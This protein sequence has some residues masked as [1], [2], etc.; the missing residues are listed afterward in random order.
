VGVL[1][2][3]GTDYVLDDRSARALPIDGHR[4]RLVRGL[5]P[6]AG[7]RLVRLRPAPGPAPMVWPAL[8]EAVAA[9]LREHLEAPLGNRG[10]AGIALLAGRMRDPSHD[11]GWRRRFGRGAAMFQA[12]C[13]LFRFIEHGAG[14]GLGRP[15]FANALR[16]LAREGGFAALAEHAERWRAIGSMWSAVADGALPFSVPDLGRARQLL[17]ARHENFLADG[18]DGPGTA[19]AE[20]LAPLAR[21]MDQAFPL[22]PADLAFLH[23]ELAAQLDRLAAAERLASER[24]LAALDT[25]RA[26]ARTAAR[27]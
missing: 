13:A 27:A 19:E 20:R 23:A 8:I 4:L 2:H 21:G 17:A 7:R 9:G 16:R 12:H 10:I 24:L 3:E 11:Q 26:S 22:S 14:P 25:V 1:G 6:V 15:L 5:S 18:L